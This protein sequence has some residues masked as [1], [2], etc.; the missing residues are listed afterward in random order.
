[1]AAD[2]A[3]LYVMTIARRRTERTE[4]VIAVERSSLTLFDG[5]IQLGPAF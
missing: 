3:F 5:I 1:M 4:W 2:T